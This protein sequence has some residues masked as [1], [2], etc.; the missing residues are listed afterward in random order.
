MKILE[1][2][3]IGKMNLRNRVA[4]MP[5]GVNL[6]DVDGGFSARARDYYAARAKGGTG[7]IITSG[8]LVTSQFEEFDAVFVL[9]SKKHLTRLND[10]VEDLHSYGSKLC[11]QLTPGLGRIRSGLPGFDPNKEPIAPSPQPMLWR[12]D[13]MARG[14]TK[15]E[16]HFL[17]KAFGNAALI[18][19]LAG[20][21][22]IE[23]HGYGG[24]LLD[25]FCT[26]LWNKRTD[27][28]GGS[29]ENR[30]RLPKEIIQEVKTVCGKDFPVIY[31]FTPHHMLEGG[32][33]LD[34]GLEMAK[35]LQSY[36]VDAL[37]IDVGCYERWWLVTPTVYEKP[38][39]AIPIAAAVKNVVDIP[40]IAMGK[41]GDPELAESILQEGKADFIGLGRSLLAD[42]EWV[43][44]LEEHKVED[45][46]P[47]IACFEGCAFRVI[48]ERYVSCGLNPQTGKEKELVIDPALKPKKVLVIG[49]GPGGMETARRAAQRG[50]KVTLWEKSG[51]LGGKLIPA[52]APG[53]KKEVERYIN[54]LKTQIYKGGVD[55]HLMQ[56]ATA[57][58][59]LR[60]DAD[61][62]VIATGAE[63]SR[64]GIPGI[65]KGNVVSACDA[66]L[67]PSITGNKVIVAGAGHV[68]CETALYLKELGKEVILVE[69]ASKILP[70][71]T[72]PNNEMKINAMIAEYGIT[73]FTG[74]KISKILDDGVEVETAGETK[75]IKGDTVVLALGFESKER[76]ASELIGKKKVFTIGDCASPRKIMDAV[77]EG[78]H[79]ARNI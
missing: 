20:V 13:I 22:A 39:S 52:S 60:T 38:G 69:M 75:E 65:D 58:K 29:F 34:E 47:C 72:F 2:G 9:E 15:D 25:Q 62:V 79:V 45:I 78:F 8:T 23:V 24:Y 5:M 53:F 37:H 67:E 77:W 4:M 54:F 32:R 73:V 31:K 63:T 41:L 10:L 6:K 44:K 27:E 3:K 55:V 43:N 19:K 11:L 49:G 16:I 70:E 14:L 66:L 57:E 71:P 35:L 28:Y 61:V 18:C 30:M 48:K 26:P 40:V 36:G 59:I 68:G 21:D 33:T 12:E 51:K 42:P 1:P 17:V 50:H 64:P 76:I 56:E 46:I 7:L 74:T